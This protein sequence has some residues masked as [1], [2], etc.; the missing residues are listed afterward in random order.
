MSNVEGF[1]D[2]WLYYV[3]VGNFYL[4]HDGQLLQANKHTK[5]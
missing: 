3:S 1:G 5:A 2:N 4:R